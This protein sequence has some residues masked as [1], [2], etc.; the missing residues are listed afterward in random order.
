[1]DDESGESMELMKEV[2]LK[3]LGDA[4]VC[5]SHQTLSLTYTVS[6][7]KLVEMKLREPHYFPFHI[8]RF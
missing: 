7:D 3:E 4:E 1:M 6:P 8:T 2:T 5:L